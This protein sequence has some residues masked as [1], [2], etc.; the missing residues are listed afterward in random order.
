[1]ILRLAL[2]SLCPLALLAEAP[3]PD[4]KEILRRVA[5]NQEKA[6]AARLSI[7]YTQ[8]TRTRLMRGGGKLAREEKR[9]YTVTPTATATNKKLDLFEGQYRKGGK[10]L[11]YTDPKFRHKEMDIDG[12]LVE[13]M[14]D[15]MVN[16]KESRDGIPKNLFPLTAK[17]QEH[18]TFHLAG[19]QKANGVDAIRVAFEPK[20]GQE[21]R[22][23][24]GEVL[25][26]PVEFQPI[27]VV[28]RLSFNIPWAVKVFLGTNIR[29]LGYTVTYRKVVGGLWFPISY[30][31]EFHLRVLFGY[32]RTIALSLDNRDFR[33]A[34]ADS[35][36]HFETES[37]LETKPNPE[38]TAH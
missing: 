4:P 35:T 13:D 14:T 17:E 18:Y 26:D 24:T 12:D 1:M 25:V 16:D 22:P 27:R 29:Q 11:P 6:V 9:R 21:E 19:V 37:H 32:A 31:T 28:T 34:S 8:E 15:D 2:F 7:V 30:G 3:Q 36:I 38:T 23:W 10:L 33:Q 20:K 5:E